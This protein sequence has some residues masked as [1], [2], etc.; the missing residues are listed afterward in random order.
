MN[1]SAQF[2]DQIQGTTEWSEA[3]GVVRQQFEDLAAQVKTGWNTNH[4]SDGTHADV[5]AS[6]L[7]L[8]GAR[9]GEFTDLNYWSSRFGTFIALGTGWIVE[10]KDVNYL[11]WSRVGQ[12]AFLQFSIY[13]SS[14]QGIPITELLID[15]PEVNARQVD[16]NLLGTIAQNGG[17]LSWTDADGT[18]I[19]YCYISVNVATKSTA[20]FLDK[21]HTV[22]GAASGPRSWQVG[23]NNVN[24]NGSIYF[25]L[26][27]SNTRRNYGG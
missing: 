7:S 23:A 13:N 11:R 4:N 16:P 5:E 26:E 20:L 21:I 17:S 24:V 9:A 22:A 12:L 2:L 14:V 18:G 27:A 3:R 19:G 8:Q 10:S 25:M 1:I 6:S 15:L